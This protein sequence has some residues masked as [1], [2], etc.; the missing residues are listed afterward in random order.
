[1]QSESNQPKENEE[2]NPDTN[3]VYREN[4]YC[5][6]KLALFERDEYG[7]L[8]EDG[9]ELDG[10]YASRYEAE[11]RDLLER[12]HS[13]EGCDP[14]SMASYQDNP[15]LLS[16]KWDV[17]NV[18]GTL[19][20][21]IHVALSSPLTSSEESMLRLWLSGQNSDGF[22]EGLE[23]REFEIDDGEGYISF[24]NSGRDY[25]IKNETEFRQYINNQTMEGLKLS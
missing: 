4:Y 11:I 21:C 16:A 15:K 18:N 8:E 14:K 25:F 17:E 5:P 1:M 13:Y 22:G 19:Y 20:G 10:R 2:S 9:Y 24:W 6:L 3:N 12:E 23:Q 7:Y